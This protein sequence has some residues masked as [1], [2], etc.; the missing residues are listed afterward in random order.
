MRRSLTILPLKSL[1]LVVG[2]IGSIHILECPHYWITSFQECHLN[3]ELPDTSMQISCFRNSLGNALKSL[4]STPDLLN[5]TFRGWEAEICMFSKTCGVLRG[6][7]IWESLTS[8]FSW[9]HA[10]ILMPNVLKVKLPFNTEIWKLY[11]SLPEV[12]S[13]ASSFI[14]KAPCVDAK[15]LGWGKEPAP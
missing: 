14:L 12:V 7:Q 4:G 15:G 8:I 1:N 3:R 6:S 2:S 13:F 5:Q 9:A 11:E 10:K